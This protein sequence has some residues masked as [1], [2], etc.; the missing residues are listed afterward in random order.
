M[1]WREEII[2]IVFSRLIVPVFKRTALSPRSA[3]PTVNE[4]RINNVKQTE[5]GRACRLY[6]VSFPRMN[7]FF[8]KLKGQK[9]E[10]LCGKA[11]EKPVWSC[12]RVPHWLGLLKYQLTFCY[13]DTFIKRR[14]TTI[15]PSC[16][17]AGQQAQE[18]LNW[19]RMLSPNQK[20]TWNLPTNF[21]HIYVFSSVCMREWG[22]AGRI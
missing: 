20:H 1:H 6:A 13:G 7:S 11:L 3:D 4:D 8:K 9:S 2:S 12:N 18:K 5:W 14:L 15:H 16:I 19:P 21:S 17:A 10:T 22:R